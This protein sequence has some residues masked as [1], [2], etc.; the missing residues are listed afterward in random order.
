MA[1]WF[2]EG[3]MITDIREAPFTAWEALSIAAGIEQRGP[4][5]H[6]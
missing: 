3:A 1:A 6:I 2:S 4:G 5:K